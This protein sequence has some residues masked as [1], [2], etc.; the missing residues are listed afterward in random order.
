VVPRRSRT[1][2]RVAI[3]LESAIA[4]HRAAHASPQHPPASTAPPPPATPAA[5]LLQEAQLHALA[6]AG[7]QCHVRAHTELWGEPLVWGDQHR[8]QSAAEC[9]AACAAYQ[10]AVGRGGLDKGVNS[11]ICN[12][13]VYC[14]DEAG[15]GSR[16]VGERA[17]G[18]GRG[19]RRRL[20]RCCTLLNPTPGASIPGH[21]HAGA[22]LG[23]ALWFPCQSTGPLTH[24]PLLLL[25][26]LLRHQECWLKH[27][28]TMPPPSSSLGSSA[29]TS[30]LVYRGD[31]WL[32]QYSGQGSLT[33]HFRLGDVA[34][35]LLPDL[36]PASARELRRLAALLAPS[37]GHCAGC[38]CAVS[39]PWAQLGSSRSMAISPATIARHQAV[40][41]AATSAPPTPPPLQAVPCRGKLSGAG[42]HQPPW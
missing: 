39:R 4:A 1:V 40:L 13:W 14:G 38:R 41:R 27:Q 16:W 7:T 32:Q 3:E 2:A 29:W 31:E 17:K 42:R 26:L 10:A 28:A 35:Q 25:L 20:R 24:L 6:I 5:G 18:R 19:L 37:G 34:V 12:T 22:R 30:G 15:C 9:C 8:V 21:Q 11:S 33:L 36:A 23:P